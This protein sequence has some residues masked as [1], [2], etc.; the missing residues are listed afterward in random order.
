MWTAD[1]FGDHLVS[2]PHGGT[3]KRHNS[4]CSAIEAIAVATGL[5]VRTEV[6]VQG[7]LRPADLA[8]SHW[9]GGR[10]AAVDPTVVHSLNPSIPWDLSQSAV[11]RAEAAKHVKSDAPC[12]AADMDFI[13]VAVDTFG[14]YGQEEHRFLSQLFSKYA[15]RHAGDREVS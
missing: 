13:P 1:V 5:R 4:L 7:R 8:L 6:A 2:C 12:A 3:W 15:K 10:D 14:G 9:S 11:D